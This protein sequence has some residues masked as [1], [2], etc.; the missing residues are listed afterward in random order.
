MSAVCAGNT[1]ALSCRADLR[2]DVAVGQQRAGVRRRNGDRA[3]RRAVTDDLIGARVTILR[4]DGRVVLAEPVEHRAAGERGI[5]ATDTGAHR[6]VDIW[7]PE[8]AVNLDLG[9]HVAAVVVEVRQWRRST[10]RVPAPVDTPRCGPGAPDTGRRP[11]HEQHRHPDPKGSRHTGGTGERH[12]SIR[13]SQQNWCAMLL[14][15]RSNA[16]CFPAAT[17]G[18]LPHP[19]ATR[20]VKESA[21]STT[22]RAG[23]PLASVVAVQTGDEADAS[24]HRLCAAGAGARAKAANYVAEKKVPGTGIEPVRGKPPQDFKSCVSASSTTPA[25]TT[26]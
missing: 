3:S 4:D 13:P 25:H 22:E 9:D 5:E 6:R 16:M 12:L 1:W 19:C 8:H 15:A 10:R 21:N 20:S 14:P 2:L 23:A 18:R 26:I 7:T 17:T 24:A 11:A